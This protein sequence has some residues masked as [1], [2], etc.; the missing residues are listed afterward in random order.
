VAIVTLPAFPAPRKTQG[1]A[2]GK[3]RSQSKR[4][5]SRDPDAKKAPPAKGCPNWE[6]LS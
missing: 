2:Q 6:R 4:T 5:R 1:N 3:V